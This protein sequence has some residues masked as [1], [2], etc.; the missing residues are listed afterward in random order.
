MLTKNVP[1]LN[2]C[3]SHMQSVINIHKYCLELFCLVY[4]F[5]EKVNVLYYLHA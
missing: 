5:H 1:P 3:I 4:Y 2:V